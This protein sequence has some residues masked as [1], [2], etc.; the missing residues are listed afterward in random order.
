MVIGSQIETDRLGTM[1]EV[2]GRV[3]WPAARMANANARVSKP[4]LPLL[5]PPPPD[6]GDDGGGVNGATVGGGG[7]GA[8][9]DG[10]FLQESA[11]LMAVSAYLPQHFDKRT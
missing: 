8:A 2:A 3:E 4:L 11:Q 5:Q 7:D 10:A 1:K 6:D 9:G